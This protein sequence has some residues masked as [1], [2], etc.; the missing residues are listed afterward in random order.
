MGCRH[1]AVAR[2]R[3]KIQL[4]VLKL[5]KRAVV[6]EQMA[7]AGVKVLVGAADFSV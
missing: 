1:S 4:D 2:N 6:Q 5:D 7:A 3:A